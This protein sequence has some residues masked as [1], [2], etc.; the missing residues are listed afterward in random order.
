M[1]E[2]VLSRE[3]VP[4][5]VSPRAAGGFTL[6]RGPDRIALSAAE[7]RRLLAAAED[8]LSAPGDE[9]LGQ[10]VRYTAPDPDIARTPA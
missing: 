7:A 6:R 4:L 8:L 5:H 2:I 1:S 3:G 10:I 9:P